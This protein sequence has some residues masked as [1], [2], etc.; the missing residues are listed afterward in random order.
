[1][2]KFAPA[3]TISFFD[4]RPHSSENIDLKKGDSTTCTNM[5]SRFLIEPSTVEVAMVQKRTDKSLLEARGKV[6]SRFAT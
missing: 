3:K 4:L 5:N 2:R 6:D 1:L